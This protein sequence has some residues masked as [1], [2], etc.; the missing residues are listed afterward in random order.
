[1]MDNYQP[2]CVTKKAKEIAIKHVSKRI[3][4]GGTLLGK[5]TERQPLEQSFDASRVQSGVL[6]MIGGSFLWQRMWF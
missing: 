6:N 3:D 2:L 1:M 5:I 4:E